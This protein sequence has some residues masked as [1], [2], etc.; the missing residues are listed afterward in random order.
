MYVDKKKEPLKF[1]IIMLQH[2]ICTADC[3]HFLEHPHEDNADYEKL[4]ELNLEGG[5]RVWGGKK[6]QFM[7]TRKAHYVQELS[8]IALKAL[9]SNKIKLDLSNKYEGPECGG[10]EG[11]WKLK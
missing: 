4:Q 10:P 3:R 2:Q 11:P 9:Q 6:L 8:G 1:F 5:E 7:N